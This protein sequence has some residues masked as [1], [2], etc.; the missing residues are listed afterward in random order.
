MNA[1]DALGEELKTLQSEL[2]QAEFEE[3]LIECTEAISTAT[4]IDYG[5]VCE[6]DTDCC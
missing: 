1:A 3:T 4:G 2:S 6:A 5:D